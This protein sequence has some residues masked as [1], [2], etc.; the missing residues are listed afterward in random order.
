[1]VTSL[2]GADFAA[3]VVV[4]V[5]A[6]AGFETAADVGCVAGAGAAAAT[7][8]GSAVD[9]STPYKYTDGTFNDENG[10]RTNGAPWARVSRLDAVIPSSSVR[11]QL[12][13]A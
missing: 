3:G 5:T 1:L 2:A 8:A 11:N 4:L 7:A 9:A 13:R 6:A 10:W 12:T